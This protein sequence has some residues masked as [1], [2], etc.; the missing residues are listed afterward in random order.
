MTY[1]QRLSLL[2]M[3]DSLIVLLS[4]YISYFLVSANVMV[5]ADPLIVTSSVALLLGY[6]L[7]AFVYTLYKKAWEYASIGELIGIVKAV[8]LSIVTGVAVQYIAVQEFHVRLMAVTWM[9]MMILIGGSRFCW[10]LMRNVTPKQE[11]RSLYKRTLIVGAGS[12]GTMVAR[13]LLHSPDQDM[14]P[15]AFVDDNRHKH[16]LDVLGVPVVGGTRA[17][18]QIARD[19]QIELIVIAIPSL[20]KPGLKAIFDECAKTKA[21]TQIIPMI[22]DIASG[23][24]SVSQFRDVQ[25][26]DLLGREPVELDLASI[27]D[28]ATGKVIL[29]TGAGGS[30]GSE[31]CRQISNFNPRKLIL[32][33]HGENSIYS[34]EMELQ[35]L[36]KDKSIQFYTEIADLQDESKIVRVLNKHRPD[37]VYHAAA[38]K[39]VP[40]MQRHPEEAVKNNVIGTLNAA[41]A[42]SQA[43]VSTFVM[44]STDKAVNPTNVMGATK[45]IAEM[46]IQYMDEISPTTFVAVRFGNVLGSRGSVIPLFKKQ[47][48]RGGPVTVTHPDMVRYFMTI[49]EASR[50][51]IQAGALA[52]GGEIFVLDMGD[53]VKIVDLAKNVI[54]LSGY[55]VEEIGIEFTGIRPGEKLY[56]ELL[57]EGEIHEQRAY[58]KIYIGK[59][60]QV[61]FKEIEYLLQVYDKLPADE[62]KQMLLDLANKKVKPRELVKTS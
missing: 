46:I 4:I 37:V 10:R 39:H 18:E 57:T 15:V 22:E 53:P 9:I 30:V 23:K 12:A 13:Q 61:N 54:R 6:H 32:L 42:S 45:R 24:V 49:P 47:V 1:K 60:S 43:G 48:E 44:I 35:N 21:K 51:V 19:Y 55:S 56:E 27:S 3:L 5:F 11:Q 58:P 25:V 33:G 31:I 38:H 7:F 40:L 36:F 17:I 26:E 29:V 8:T 34:I 16:G 59:S 41:K 2:A 52:R 20:D 50:L 28:C 14:R 62:L